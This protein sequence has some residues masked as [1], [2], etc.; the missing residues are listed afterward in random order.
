M[1]FR[2]EWKS[3]ISKSDVM[4]LDHRLSAVTRKDAHARRGHYIIHSLYFR[5]AHDLPMNPPDDQPGKTETFR[6][7]YYNNNPDQIKL[8]K[9]TEANG[10]SSLESC[11]ITRDFVSMILHNRF[12]LIVKD[13]MGRSGEELDPLI[14]EFY[15]NV[16]GLGMRPKMIMDYCRRPYLYPNGNVRVTIDYNFKS[17]TN[18]Q[19]FLN[20]D[21]LGTELSDGRYFLKVKWNNYLPEVIRSA[22]TL[23]NRKNSIYY[24][25]PVRI[26]R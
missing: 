20:P 10:M 14:Q 12:D 25:D 2:N 7:R 4:T 26:I 17:G 18:V 3:A 15:W 5:E 1:E 16:V 9:K 19:D 22:V 24:Y 8:E 23:F 11:E 6:I 21:C 13:P